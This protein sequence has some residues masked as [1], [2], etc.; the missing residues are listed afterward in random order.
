MPSTKD[1]LISVL[2]Q[3]QQNRAGLL[4]NI[5]QAETQLLTMR[6]E[7]DKFDSVI[8][9]LQV[10]I[11]DHNVLGAVDIQRVHASAHPL[12]GP[13]ANGAATVEGSFTAVEEAAGERAGGVQD[14][15]NDSGSAA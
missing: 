9:S 11:A 6:G 2:D 3:I 10:S 14:L 8:A 4:K 5:S 15:A 1:H 7:V 13:S 12:K